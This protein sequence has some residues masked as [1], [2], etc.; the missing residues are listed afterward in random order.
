MCYFLLPFLEID[1]CME[2]FC[3]SYFWV[4]PGW[5]GAGEVCSIIIVWGFANGFL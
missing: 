4:F 5:V 2:T 1:I 3:T